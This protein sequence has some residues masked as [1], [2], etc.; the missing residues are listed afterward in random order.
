MSDKLI[1]KSINEMNDDTW[2]VLYWSNQ[3]GWTG[4]EEADRFTEEEA[5]ALNL[6][7]GGQWVYESAELGVDTPSSEGVKDA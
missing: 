5:S 7:V 2:E 1:I 3:W 4:V 6:P